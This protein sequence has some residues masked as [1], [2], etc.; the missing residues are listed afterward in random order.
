MRALTNSMLLYCCYYYCYHNTIFLLQSKLN[1]AALV[2]TSPVTAAVTAPTPTTLQKVLQ[3][4]R[5]SLQLHNLQLQG[6]YGD[7]VSATSPSGMSPSGTDHREP[8]L[9]PPVRKRSSR[10]AVAPVAA[11][12]AVAAADAPRVRSASYSDVE[13]GSAAAT[14]AAPDAKVGSNYST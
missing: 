6:Q 8:E 12:A 4:R 3:E 11:T 10:A 9:T 1:T 2:S 5:A 14:T 13:S 7:N